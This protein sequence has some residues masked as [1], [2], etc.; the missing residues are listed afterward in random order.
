MHVNGI[1]G[2]K[3]AEREAKGTN[4]VPFVETKTQPACSRYIFLMYQI[5]VNRCK[6]HGPW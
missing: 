3:A 2:K 4:K 5:S 6:N 1:K